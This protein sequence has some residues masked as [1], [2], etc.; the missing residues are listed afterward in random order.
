MTDNSDNNWAL[1]S[2]ERILHQLG[3]YVRHER[4]SQNR[5]QEA[6]STSAGLSRSTLS[7]LENGQEVTIS[8]FIRVLRVLDKLNL[9]DSFTIKQELS[10]IAIAKTKRQERKRASGTQETSVPPK[11]DW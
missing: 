2:D 6:L 3:A 7:L 5:T 11:V 10:P 4:L 9:L 8:S 1:L